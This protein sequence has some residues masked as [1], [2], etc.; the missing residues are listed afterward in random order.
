MSKPIPVDPDKWAEMVL[1]WSEL[2]RWKEM[3]DELNARCDALKA[4]VEVLDKIISRN[5]EYIQD[6]ALEIIALKAENERLRA[7]SFVTAVP[8]EDYEK[9]K[10][11]NER[12]RKAGDAMAIV[13]LKWS[14]AS[15]CLGY[16]PL[17][18]VIIPAINAWHGAKH[19]PTDPTK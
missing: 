19:Q 1:A 17:S 15:N 12:L 16:L 10:A 5:T 6:Q 4:E 9:L 7:S 14:M 18:E 8:S 11:E 2:P 13:C 3:C